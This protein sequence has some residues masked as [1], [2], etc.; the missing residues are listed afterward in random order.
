MTNALEKVVANL[1]DRYA[2][3][4]TNMSS[5]RNAADACLELLAREG[6][7][8]QCE[9]PLGGQVWRVNGKLFGRTDEMT[10]K[11][12]DAIVRKEWQ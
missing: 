5:H 11:K 1:A 2:W 9:H 10:L 12:F 8:E 3:N 7:I 4:W 6:L